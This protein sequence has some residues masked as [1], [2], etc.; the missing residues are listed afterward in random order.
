V[1]KRQI[2][3]VE[4]KKGLHLDLYDSSRNVAG[5]RWQVVLTASIKMPNNA[6]LPRDNPQSTLN[7]DEAMS[8]LP[9]ST[10]FEQRRERNFIDAK[11]KDE[12]CNNL[13]ESFL[14]SS[15][16]YVSNPDFPKRYIL[17]QNRELLK[18]KSWRP[19]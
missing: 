5:D 12:V 17:H 9:N 4:L 13:V 2:K 10:S 7:G 14:T 18:R 11:E 6:L 15:I 1:D 16:D 8:S 19:D 3:S